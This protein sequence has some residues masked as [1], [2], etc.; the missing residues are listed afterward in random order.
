MD[1]ET[2]YVQRQPNFAYWCTYVSLSQ[3]PVP[4]LCYE[5]ITFLHIFTIVPRC[6]HDSLSTFS[7][8]M[9][10]SGRSLPLEKGQ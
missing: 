1:K 2:T 9:S 6:R 10:L 4:K 7:R 8:Q 5:S 3:Q